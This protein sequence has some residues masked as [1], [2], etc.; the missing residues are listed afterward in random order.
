M[1]EDASNHEL[2]SSGEEASVSR[3]S[4]NP[5]N[6]RSQQTAVLINPITE[7]TLR[8]SL[9]MR[10]SEYPT[11]NPMLQEKALLHLNNYLSINDLTEQR[12]ETNSM[13][14]SPLRWVSANKF[15]GDTPIVPVPKPKTR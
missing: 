9:G 6:W 3:K 10:S 4:P 13:K 2:V 5:M 12:L 15:K 1:E 8:S 14:L 7:A 11:G